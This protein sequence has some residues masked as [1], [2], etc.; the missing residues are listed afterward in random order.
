MTAKD[1]GKYKA[2]LKEERLAH[3]KAK[4]ELKRLERF[5]IS[6]SDPLVRAIVINRYINGLTWTATAMKIGG[7][8]TADNCRKIVTRYLIR[9]NR[10]K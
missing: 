9:K 3:Q 10:K 2:C 7:N 6:C 8:I 5:V 4:V 1:L